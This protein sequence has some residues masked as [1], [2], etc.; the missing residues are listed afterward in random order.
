[1]SISR[2]L[3][4]YGLLSVLICFW[5]CH[6]LFFFPGSPFEKGD[7]R[8]QSI[9]TAV[10][11]VTF[12]EVQRV[13]SV[14]S[15]VWT[16][17]LD[18]AVYGGATS[19]QARAPALSSSTAAG[20]DSLLELKRPAIDPEQVARQ[21]VEDA[22]VSQRRQLHDRV[23]AAVRSGS[24]PTLSA[25]F[26][27]VGSV[28]YW[29][30]APLASGPLGSA[31]TVLCSDGPLHLACAHGD[32]AMMEALLSYTYSTTPGFAVQDSV[33]NRVRID[34]DGRDETRFFR[35]ALHVAAEAGHCD[36]LELL[37]EHHANPELRDSKKQTPYNLCK[38]KDSRL[39]FRNFASAHQDT[40]DW[41]AACVPV[42][43]ETEAER[44][45]REQDKKAKKRQKEKDR[46][47]AK[48]ERERIEKEEAAAEAAA[49]LA[50]VKKQQTRMCMP[51][52][53][54][55]FYH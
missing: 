36:L 22:M 47:K 42:S 28:P 43:D 4:Q 5:L 8:V 50:R 38:D 25:V 26:A 39:V 2:S 16:V 27:E 3:L 53:W 37:L 20:V 10:R 51:S 17:T 35:T 41:T 23:T 46:L 24:V 55:L 31:G 6:S 19:L 13:Y 15:T 40:W 1:M 45:Q 52:L 14:L 32:T 49:E 30:P 7:A 48:K 11:N 34:I 33:K 44:L 18:H 9:P 54:R 29:Y 21:Q 12:Q